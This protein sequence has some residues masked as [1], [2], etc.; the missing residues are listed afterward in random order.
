[1]D[2]MEVFKIFA[3]VDGINSSDSIFN[4]SVTLDDKTKSNLKIEGEL[5]SK[6]QIGGIYEFTAARYLNQERNTAFVSEVKG[7]NDFD[8]IEDKNKV[9]R[10]F[11]NCAPLQLE[12]LKNGINEYLNKIDDKIIYEITKGVLE[13][14]SNDFYLY[15]AASR[16]HHA[17]IGGLAYHTLKMLDMVD[18]FLENYQ[19]FDRNLV[20]AGVILH[21]IGKVIEFTGIENLQY[22]VEGQLLGHLIIGSH[23]ILEM[24]LKLGYEKTEEVLLLQHMLISHHGQPS[25]GSAKRPAIP[26]AYLLYF[27]DNIDSKFRVL[28]EELDKTEIKN[29]TEPIGVLE[30]TKIYKHR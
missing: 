16:F 25:Y 21:D 13:K 29:F 3:R 10:N 22:G 12:E 7:I 8:S 4:L 5:S 18:A 6:I 14:Y 23:E 20:Y 30:R 28:K 19:C 1:M 27:L 26:E 17:Y 24:A 2:N 15:P 11:I 9:Y